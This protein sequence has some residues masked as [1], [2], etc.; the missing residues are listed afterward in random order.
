MALSVASSF[1]N[2]SLPSSGQW[3]DDLPSSDDEQIVWS[4]SSSGFLSSPGPAVPGSPGSEVSEYVLVPRQGRSTATERELQE[5][6]ASLSLVPAPT[7]ANAKPAPRPSPKKRKP[8]A[9]AAPAAAQPNAPRPQTPP[10]KQKSRAK[11]PLAS[12][13]P[14]DSYPSPPASPKQERTGTS[15]PPPATPR[16]TKK[17]SAKPAKL[18]AAPAEG[19]ASETGLGARTVVDD[20]SEAGDQP[21]SPA[22]VEA[23]KYMNDYLDHP[24]AAGNNG[25]SLLVLQALILELGLQVHSNA[26]RAQKSAPSYFSI[27]DLPR[28]LRQAK[29]LLKSQAFINV[30][31][32]LAVREQGQ[33]ALQGVMHPNRQSLVK[34]VRKGK[35]MPVKEVKKAGL[36]VLLVNTRA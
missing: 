20:V 34:E 19:G 9:S 31:D 27:P 17:R 12:S 7:T 23:R 33:A 11:S 8:K 25:S 14:S 5:A 3:A 36:N 29:L 26:V 35:K 16:K 30:R 10:K 6:L 13:A 32:Y 18:P 21:E 15:T 22:Y 1:D 2:I 4:L 28:T 24:P